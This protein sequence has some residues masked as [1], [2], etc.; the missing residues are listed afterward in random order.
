MIILYRYGHLLIQQ[1]ATT[2]KKKK[3]KKYGYCI[4][5]GHGIWYSCCN[6]NIIFLH[7]MHGKDMFNII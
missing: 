7:A 2:K 6:I 3:K 4:H 1:E 5:I